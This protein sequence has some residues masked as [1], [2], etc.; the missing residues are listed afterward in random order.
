MKR[1]VWIVF[2]FCFI[3]VYNVNVVGQGVIN[4]NGYNKILYPNGKI[5]SE[6][7]MKNGKPDGYWK[8]YYPSGIIKSE[9]NRKNQLLDSTW[10]FYN[11]KGDTIEKVNYILGKRNGYTYGYN[12]LTGQDPINKGKII[13]K[14]LY[15][16]DKKE[17]MSVY[18]FAN[19]QQRENIIYA[20]NKRQGNSMIYDEKGNVITIEAY[21]KGVLTEREKINR[22]DNEGL[23]QG[24]WR[25]YYANGRIKSEYYYKDDLLNGDLKEYDENGN[26]RIL[27]HYAKGSIIETNDTSSIDVEIINKYDQEGNLS[28]S[29]SYKNGIPV[30]IHRVYDNTG[31]VINSILYGEGGLK[32]GEGII[33]NE[34]KRE[35]EWRYYYN[36]GTIMSKGSF[37][38]NFESGIW[39]FYYK[40]EKVEQS[41]V[42]KNGKED[43]LWEWFYE[44]GS[45][46]REE[47]YYNGKQEGRYVEY[48]TVGNLIASG[49]YFEDQKEGDWTYQV[50]DNTEKGKYIGDLKDGKWQSFYSNGKLKYQGNFIQGNPDGEH[51]FY[52]PNGK[53]SEINYYVMG[54]SEKN[55]KKFDDSG[56][57]LITITYKNNR[58]YR[59]NG[60]KIEFA[61]EDVKLIQ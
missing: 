43:G 50:G 40:N 53:I 1:K 17:G 55:W 5:A 23:K 11:E 19:G 48:D 36:D 15:L 46:K 33:T 7:F 26:I 44:N 9:G 54:I 39:K 52:F 10:C 4:E 41:G 21:F 13:S 28:F 57:L 27:L 18:F 6:G 31:K 37:Q 58:E 29:G 25:T 32:V 24:I 35:G 12:N 61:A 30:G 16:N 2:N 20:D 3:I 22:T 59:I 14:E 56:N 47:E 60:E 49:S 45:I 34:G 38:N 51:I 8:T 42:Y